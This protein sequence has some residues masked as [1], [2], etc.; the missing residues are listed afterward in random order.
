MQDN[1]P[2][3]ARIHHDPDDRH[4][5]HPQQGDR[6]EQLQR[7]EVEGVGFGPDQRLFVTVARRHDQRVAELDQQ[8]FPLALVERPVERR[9]AHFG[10][11]EQHV[12]Q[13]CGDIFS[14]CCGQVAP[15]RGDIAVE[16]VHHMSFPVRRRIDSEIAFHSASSCASTAPPSS[17]R[18]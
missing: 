3:I 4:H 9:F 17:L 16:Q 13:F 1:L 14:L 15:H 10:A 18:R 8:G 7:I 12:A 2:G 6:A 11:F 5:G